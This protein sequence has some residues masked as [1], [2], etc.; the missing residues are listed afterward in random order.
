MRRVFVYPL[1]ALVFLAGPMPAFADEPESTEVAANDTVATSETG[2]DESPAADEAAPGAGTSPDQAESDEAAPSDERSDTDGSTS[3]GTS[4]APTQPEP[5]PKPTAAT[6]DS[7]VEE[8]PS[9]PDAARQPPVLQPRGSILDEGLRLEEPME[10]SGDVLTEP[11]EKPYLGIERKP[12]FGRVV[13]WVPR[14]ILFPLYVVTDF[15]VRRP[16]GFVL[17]NIEEHHVIERVKGATT[18]GDSEGPGSNGG[19]VP[20]LRFDR[21]LRPAI[22]LEFYL[23]DALAAGNDWHVGADTDFRQ[24]ASADVGTKLR[25]KNDRLVFGTEGSFLRQADNV[26]H[27]MGAA[28]DEAD[29]TRF[30]SREFAAGIWSSYT[31]VYP[32]LAGRLRGSVSDHDFDCSPAEDLDICGDD[33]QAGTDDDRYDITQPTAV[34][35]FLEGYQ[36]LTIDAAIAGDTRTFSPRSG[37]GVRA[38]VFSRFGQGIVGADDLR[39]VTLGSE[40][41]GYINLYQ[42]R[43]IGLKVRGEVAEPAGTSQIPF[44]EL[45]TL[46]GNQTMRGFL[47]GRFRGRSTFAT[48][49]EYRYPIWSFVDGTVFAEAGNAFGVGFEGLAPGALQGSF[50]TGF[51]SAEGSDLGFDLLVAVGTT[52]FDEDLA[53]EHARLTLGT[54]WDF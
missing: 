16:I 3:A 52:R 17:T 49:L 53:V 54:D 30:V 28:V 33:H 36:L 24:N 23:V 37:T 50:G 22:G 25:L 35:Y 51:R 10:P 39:F 45:S 18:F 2:E 11:R 26:F 27:G 6:P 31:P 8:P 48:T 19:V 29:E 1:L 43:V 9:T 34:P 20:R 32:G 42:G 21:R 46:G 44:T 13:A 38:E 4:E 41:A 47:E 40:I 15:V 14:I 5:A 12:T 7:T